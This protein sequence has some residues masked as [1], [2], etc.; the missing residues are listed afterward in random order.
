[1][2]RLHDA[3]L[4]QGCERGPW[5]ETAICNPYLIGVAA[6]TQSE[7]RRAGDEIEVTSEMIEAGI[8]ALMR[9]VSFLDAVETTHQDQVTAVVADVYREM[10]VRADLDGAT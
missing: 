8:R 9:H 7:G 1:M 6:N 10:F 2:G 5:L 4:S 3:I